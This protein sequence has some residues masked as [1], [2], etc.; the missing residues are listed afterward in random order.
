MACCGL[1][2]HTAAKLIAVLEL[3][4]VIL[5]IALSI[6]GLIAGSNYIS[7]SPFM[8]ISYIPSV[9]STTAFYLLFS[10]ILL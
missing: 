1:H 5:V 9:F 6:I 10:V 4:L 3:L 7:G 2:V 8:G